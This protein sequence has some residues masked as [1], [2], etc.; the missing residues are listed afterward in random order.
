MKRPEMVSLTA[1][2]HFA[3]SALFFIVFSLSSSPCCPF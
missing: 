1:I 3:M 2:Y